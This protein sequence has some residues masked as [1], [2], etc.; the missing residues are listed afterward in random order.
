MSDE[1]YTPDRGKL[2]HYKLDRILGQGGTGRVYRGID[3]KKGE[4]VAIKL[5]REDFFR[6]RL[7]L[8]DLVKSVKRFRKYSH[9]NVV[10]IHDFIDGDEGKCMVM[11]YIDGPDL[12][13]Y[14]VNRPWNLQERIGIVSQICFG[15]QYLHD[16]KITHHDIKPANILFTRTGIAKLADFSLYGSSLLLEL[17]DRGAGEQITPMYVPPEI[18]RGEGATPKSDQYSLGITLYLLFAERLPFQVDN[19]QRLY[20]C[21]LNVVPDHPSLVNP[22]CPHLVGDIVLSQTGRSRI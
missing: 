22:K 9:Q 15:L 17:I 2:Y 14:L 20:Q 6:N 16:Q 21:H 12:K 5:F 8:R 10:R 13:W 4:V 3:T 1:Q 18:I 19:L 7:H 11:E